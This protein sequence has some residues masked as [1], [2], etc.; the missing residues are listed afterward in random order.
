MSDGTEFRNALSGAAVGTIIGLLLGAA[1]LSTIGLAG[2]PGLFEA[3]L[4]L[5]CAAFGGAMFGAIVGSTGL[6]ARK[7]TKYSAQR[8]A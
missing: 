8:A 5:A 4:L 1:V 3:I 2:I 6:F 7:R